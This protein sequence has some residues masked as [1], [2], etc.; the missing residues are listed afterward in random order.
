VNWGVFW[1][2]VAGLVWALGYAVVCRVW[3]YADC[4]KCKGNGRFMTPSW[5]RFLFGRGW[6]RCRRCKGTGTRI[7]FGR[8]VWAKLAKAK[9]DAVG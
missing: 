4:R 8:W 7:R 5:L 3:P 1:L 6:R 2:V 9:N